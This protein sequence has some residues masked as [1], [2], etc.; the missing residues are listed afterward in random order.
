MAM[1]L[2]PNLFPEFIQAR[3][4]ARGRC[5]A[6]LTSGVRFVQSK[7]ISLAGA[8]YGYETEKGVRASLV[9]ART[10]RSSCCVFLLFWYLVFVARM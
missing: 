5:R 9:Y 3:A 6:V 1:S 7:V 2:V 10:R 4:R 8:K